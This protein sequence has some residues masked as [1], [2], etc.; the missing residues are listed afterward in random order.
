MPAACSALPPPPDAGAE[1]WAYGATA[2]LR[3]ARAP[4]APSCPVHGPW[5]AWLPGV[6]GAAALKRYTPPTHVS[7]LG[8]PVTSHPWGRCDVIDLEALIGHEGLPRTG[9]LS[10]YTLSA[11][12]KAKELVVSRALLK[13]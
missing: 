3:V 13:K 9:G 5:G 6:S 12:S 1:C 11:Q 7:G 10:I 2:L 4:A 8:L